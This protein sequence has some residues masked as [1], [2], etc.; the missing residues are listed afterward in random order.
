MT[1]EPNSLTVSI[2]HERMP[3]LLNDEAEFEMWLSGAP[4]EAFALARSFD[5]TY[6]RIVQSG[7]DKKDLLA[8]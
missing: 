5:P 6:K 3:V 7:F 2:N 8:A 4:E 1:T